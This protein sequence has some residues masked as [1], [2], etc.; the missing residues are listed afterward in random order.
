MGY[1]EKFERT[2]RLLGE[3]GLEILKNKRVAVFG[4]GGVGGHAAEAI[5]RSGVGHIDIIDGDVVSESNINRQ[6]IALN[7]TIGM[8][9]TSAAAKRFCDINPDLDIRIHQIFFDEDSMDILNLTDYDYIVDA[10]DSVKS[11]VLLLESA[12]KAGVPVISS[13]GA[14]NKLDPTCVEVS[15][16][17][18]TSVC[19]L[20]KVMRRELKKCGVTQLKVVYSKEV[21]VKSSINN[22][23]KSS[24]RSSAKSFPIDFSDNEKNKQE[25]NDE[26]NEMFKNTARPPV[27]SISFVPSVFG[28]VMAGEVV[29]DLV[30]QN[31]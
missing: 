21:P 6:I 13:M 26:Q 15:D 27:G 24:V 9:K 23:A 3:A 5:V 17:Y 20:A 1:K 25:E 29:K 2:E 31:S 7:S 19:P 12:F 14:G 11:K 8:P 16:I 18:K 10:I 4:I 30:K 22:S 28:L